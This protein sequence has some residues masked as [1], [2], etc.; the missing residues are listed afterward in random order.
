MKKNV[1]LVRQQTVNSDYIICTKTAT[2]NHLNCDKMQVEVIESPTITNLLNIINDL[3][4][5]LQAAEE[6]IESQ[7]ADEAPYTPGSVVA[8]TLHFDDIDLDSKLRHNLKC[9]FGNR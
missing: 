5:R 9:Q 8:T 3:S 1:G 7:K 6:Y 2:I 4:T